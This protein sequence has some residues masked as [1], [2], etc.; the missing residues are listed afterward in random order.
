M[1][2]ISIDQVLTHEKLLKTGDRCNKQL[3]K[4]N[5]DPKFVK[6]TAD[7]VKIVQ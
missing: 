7:D 6:L 2:I 3:A 1:S 5:I 4:M